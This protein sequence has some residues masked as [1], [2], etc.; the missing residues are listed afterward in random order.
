MPGTM[1]A[2]TI[3]NGVLKRLDQA[4]F[5]C[6]RVYLASGILLIQALLFYAYSV[7]GPWIPL[8]IFY[9]LNLY[10]AA[11][12]VGGP[13]SYFLALVAAAGRT[14]IKVG[15]YPEDAHWWQGQW[16]FVS[17]LS[18]YAL[19]CYL[20]NAQL[21]GRREI[22]AVLD[23]LSSLNEAI[24]ADADSGIMVFKDSGECILANSAA[25]KML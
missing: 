14:Y 21:S 3:G 1:S 5:S 8:S 4:L 7:S 19:F 6:S 18:I 9:L 12:Y 10:F 15:F 11:K 25:A 13:F 16:Q 17:S 20:M 22:E 24:V 2:M 23:K